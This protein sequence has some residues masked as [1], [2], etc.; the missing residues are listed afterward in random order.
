MDF[1]ENFQFHQN[2]GTV[3]MY[4]R[5]R[6]FEDEEDDKA[7]FKSLRTSCVPNFGQKPVFSHLPLVKNMDFLVYLW[8]SDPSRAIHA[9]SYC[10]G[11]P[12]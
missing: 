10:M 7:C 12:L 6:G 4:V 3:C 9:T 5:H 1:L 8:I 11:S 2:I